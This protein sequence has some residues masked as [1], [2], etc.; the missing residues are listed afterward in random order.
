[1]I[2]A[3][4]YFY[5]GI[6]AVLLGIVWLLAG[7]A[8][9]VTA[10]L[11]I[12][13]GSFRKTARDARVLSWLAFWGGLLALSCALIATWFIAADHGG[14]SSLTARGARVRES[15]MR[16]LPPGIVV[17]IAIGANLWSRRA[18]KQNFAV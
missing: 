16:A 7:S 4:T 11:A 15:L 1:M 9:A 8:S 10:L 2:L 17:V 18:Q 6:A 12:G 5:G 14:D 13:L 3:S